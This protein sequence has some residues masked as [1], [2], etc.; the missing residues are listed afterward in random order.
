MSTESKFL[1][2]VNDDVVW[3]A[4]IVGGG[5]VGA[6]A[7]I[8]LARNGFEVLLLERKAPHWSAD[9]PLGVRV[10][11]L[12]RAS[13][14]ILRN[15]GAWEAICQQRCHAFRAMRVWD[16]FTTA[17][18]TFNAADVGETDLGHVIENDLIQYALWQ[19]FD[20]CESLTVLLD[21]EITA[22]KLPADGLS[23]SSL[24]L[25][26][27]RKLNARM[28]VAADGGRS[29][30]RQLA[31]IGLSTQDYDQCA[32]VGTVKTELSHQ[33]C[34]WQR[35][36][37]D[38]P[39]AFLAMQDNYSSIAWY[40]PKEKC[41][42]ALSLD[43]QQFAAEVG[44]ASDY[45][46]GQVVEVGG[47]GAFPLVRQHA[48]HYVKRGLALIGD[49][50]HTIHPQAGQGVNLGLLDAAALVETLSRA[51]SEGRNFTSL[52]V[53]R[54]YERWRRGD[55]AIVQRSMEWFA[56]LYQDNPLKNGFRQTMLPLAERLKPGKNWLME[57]A[58][59]GREALPEM[60]RKY[61]L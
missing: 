31:Q 53:L 23:N 34:C 52:S 42:W 46:L 58:L 3:D 5:M 25:A 48:N 26:D 11:A 28:I 2:P 45:R 22:L 43:D 54:Q 1:P 60:A 27:G 40:L 19:E 13:E 18:V 7:A 32:V 12:T 15:L 47:R 8:G 49:A 9:E 55:N 44:K 6:A 37:K 24:T 30:V 4:I 14:N 29:L 36:T 39:F 57:Q 59:N 50:A 21:Q 20:A 33:D 16:E 41:D 17:E 10:S 51:K 38:G 56:W 61:S 35:Y